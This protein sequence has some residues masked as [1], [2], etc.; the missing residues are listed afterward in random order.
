MLP[1]DCDIPVSSFYNNFLV[2]YNLP[3][4]ITTTR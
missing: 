1:E 2:I 4:L 3:V